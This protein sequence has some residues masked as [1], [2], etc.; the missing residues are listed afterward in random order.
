VYGD[1]NMV[2]L[3]A[4]RLEE[5]ALGVVACVVSTPARDRA[6]VD[7][8]S[9]ALSADLRVPGTEGFGI[10]VGKVHLL[11]ERLSEEHGV[12]SSNVATGLSVGDLV[13]II[14]THA[15]TTVNLHPDL[16]VLTPDGPIRWRSVDARGWR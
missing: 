14:P 10:V 9:K 12:L 2:R 8:G 15:C 1:A 5:C 7:A 4:Q 6:V 3:G 13:L 11:V 16:A